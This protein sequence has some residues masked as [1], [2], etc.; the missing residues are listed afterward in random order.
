MYRLSPFT[1]LVSAVLSTGI[2]GAKVTCSD[3]EILKISPPSGETCIEYLGDY[4]K[5]APANLLTPDST[6]EC[7]ICPMTDTDTYLQ[8][9]NIY[10]SDLWRNVGILFAYIIFNVFAAVALYWLLR[11]PKNNMKKQKKQEEKDQKKAQKSA[12]S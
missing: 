11:V 4:L 7:R 8:Q 3:I 5:E 9:V 6:T 12:S 1:Y 2:S 10:H